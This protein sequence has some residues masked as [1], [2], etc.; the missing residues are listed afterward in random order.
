MPPPLRLRSCSRSGWPQA[1]AAT[2]ARVRTQPRSSACR[3]SSAPASTSAPVGRRRARPSRTTPSA[4]RPAATSFTASYT[5]DGDAMEIGD[6]RVDADG[7]STAGRRGRARIPRRTRAGGSMAP[8]RLGAHSGR[9]RPQRAAPVRG[10]VTAGRLGGDGV[11]Q[12]RR[13]L[14]PAAGDEDHRQLRRRRHAD[15]LVRLQ[16]VPDG[17]HARPGQHPDRAAGG[18]RDGLRRAGGRHGP[19]DCLSRRAS[20]RCRLPARRRVALSPQRRRRG[21]SPPTRARRSRSGR[22]VA[23]RLHG[24][25][26]T[27][28]PRARARGRGARALPVDRRRRRLGRLP[29]A[30]ARACRTCSGSASSRRTAPSS[31]SG[32]R[33]SSS[34]S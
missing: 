5:V 6:G 3:G 19:G 13:G 28:R 26:P 10:G 9:R 12:R 20:D 18:D 21:S 17:V 22:R 32:T 25:A 4:A 31:R 8:R 1:A 34:R 33:R 29:G 15:G 2:T 30:R 14:E 16:H 23:V 11:P 7:L 27:A 24:R